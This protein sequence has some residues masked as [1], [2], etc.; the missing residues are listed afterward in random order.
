MIEGGA[1]PKHGTPSA[2]ECIKMFKQE[3]KWQQKFESA[4]GCG[5]TSTNSAGAIE[6]QD[7]SKEQ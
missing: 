6:T 3:E 1:D 2:L 4:L 5:K 7:G